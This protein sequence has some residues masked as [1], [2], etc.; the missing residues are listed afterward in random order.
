MRRLFPAC[1]RPAVFAVCALLFSL[2]RMPAA[3]QADLGTHDPA[4]PDAAVSFI[5]TPPV[6]FLPADSLVAWMTLAYERAQAEALSAPAAARLYAYAGVAAYESVSVFSYDTRS[7]S[8]QLDGLTALPY[9]SD[10]VAY[11]PIVVS[12]SALRIVLTELLRERGGESLDAINR[13]YAERAAA[14]EAEILAALRANPDAAP[15][16]GADDAADDGDSP[17]VLDPYT[18]W[19]VSG[20]VAREDA[21][22]VRDRVVQRSRDYG[23]LLGK[24]LAAW[25]AEDGYADMR[26]YAAEHP[27]PMPDI[28]TGREYVLTV[29]GGQPAEPYWGQ[30]VRPMLGN[31]ADVCFQ[32]NPVEYS[33]D[34]DSTFYLQALEVMNVGDSLTAE[35]RDIAAWWVDTP[36]LTGAPA[37]HWVMIQNQVVEQYGFPLLTAASMFGMTNIVIGDSFT[38]A[39]T[40]K[41]LDPLVRPITYIQ[42]HINRRWR[43]FIETPPFPEFPSGHSVVSGAAAHMLTARY[44]P[45]AFTDRTHQARGMASRAYTSFKAAGYEAAIS[46]LYGGIHYRAAIESGLEIGE[47]ISEYALDTIIMFPLSQ[48]GL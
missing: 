35:Q 2:G 26:A 8:G 32:P 29:E 19:V 34:P 39:W 33:T 15:A 18:Q 13:F 9:P 45:L 41:Y 38:T 11:D 23:D 17:T 46:R 22:A 40:M 24:A 20:R 37:G 6:A 42:E 47:C 1:N 16:Q 25:A 30:F 3:A 43:S 44:G 10:E 28:V 36:G 14:R 21:E 12:D 4:A 7:L 5:D 48:G 31:V 27:F